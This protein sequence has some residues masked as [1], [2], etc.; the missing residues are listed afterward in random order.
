MTTDYT[1]D[2]HFWTTVSGR[3]VDK[4]LPQTEMLYR[5]SSSV[6]GG[7]WVY[8][9]DPKER[10]DKIVEEHLRDI[11]DRL[12]KKGK[13]LDQAVMEGRGGK[14]DR[15]LS[16]FPSAYCYAKEN[17]RAQMV[18]G[19]FGYIEIDT[20]LVKWLFGHPDNEENAW[21]H[22]ESDE[23]I[24]YRTDPADHEGLIRSTHF[25]TRPVVVCKETGKKAK[26]N[27]KCP[28]GSSKKY[29]KCCGSN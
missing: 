24:D 13:T 25:G 21:K 3:I 14:N 12:A 6:K 9:P 20:G 26:P 7:Q 29:K 1:F 28:C 4:T 16:C 10:T 15:V 22:Y 17:A 11:T 19:C 18:S 8:L 5:V 23:L 2:L 27:E